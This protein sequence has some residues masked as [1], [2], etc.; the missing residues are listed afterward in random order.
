VTDL[1]CLSS[2]STER[3]S[4]LRCSSEPIFWLLLRN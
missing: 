4:F 1:H 3:R 2:R